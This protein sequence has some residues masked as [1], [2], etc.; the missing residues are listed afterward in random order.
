M[1]LTGPELR[2][3]YGYHKAT[4]ETG[5]MH[6]EIRKKFL[7]LATWIDA[8]LPDG[9]AK[10]V[11]LTDLENSSMWSNKAIAELAPVVDE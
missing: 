8:N 7:E 9:R 10:S 4:S 3:R 1:T 6:Q 11:A 2:N 5:P